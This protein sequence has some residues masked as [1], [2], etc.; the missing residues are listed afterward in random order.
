MEG[1][2]VPVALFGFTWWGLVAIARV[3]AVN[4]TRRKMLETRATPEQ[5]D[6]LF[7]PRP[8]AHL[9]SSLLWGL[10]LASTGLALMVL[11]ALPFGDESPFAYGFVALG[12]AVG[13]LVHYALARRAAARIA[14][15]SEG[16]TSVQREVPA[17]VG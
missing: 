8:D 6:A 1:V 13:L 11:E 5:V 15:R 10:V 16:A 14:V 17:G 2:I 12:A 7:A 3:I 4:L 9:A